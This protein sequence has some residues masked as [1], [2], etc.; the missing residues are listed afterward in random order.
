MSSKFLCNQNITL[1]AC[2]KSQPFHPLFNK[3]NR[4]T[5]DS[6]R[7]LHLSDTVSMNPA[8]HT[9]VTIAN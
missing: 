2:Y 8:T 5:N 4:D 6:S 7:N 3:P 1:N 9:H